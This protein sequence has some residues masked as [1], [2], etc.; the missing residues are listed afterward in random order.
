M[1]TTQ[2]GELAAIGTAF[3]WTLSALAWTSAGKDMGALAVSFIRLVVTCVYLSIY[4]QI[5][6]GMALPM[7]ADGETWLYLSVSGFFG[8]FIADLC[9]FKSFLLIGPRISLLLQSLSPPLSAIIAWIFLGD[10]LQMKDWIGMVITLAGVVWVVLEQPETPEEHKRR[11]HMAR[12]IFFAVVSAA[13]GAIGMVF[14][15]KGIAHYDNAVAAT[16]IRVIGAMAGYVV[17]LTLVWRWPVIFKAARHGRAMAILTFGSFV[18][19]FMGVI[20][21]MVAL[22][23]CHAGVVSTIVNTMPVLILPFLIVI[24]HEKVSLRAVGGAVLSVLGVA[25]LMW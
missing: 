3:L 24:Y 14:S 22:R 5:L 4:G 20:L 15:K 16:Y 7:D 12:G 1:D 8:F 6:R 10:M 18:G 11:R 19:P 25:L 23:Y 21:C 13:T 17:L 2:F 9:L